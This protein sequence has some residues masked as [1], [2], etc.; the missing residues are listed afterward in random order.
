MEYRPARRPSRAQQAAFDHP[1]V[2]AIVQ[3]IVSKP[4]LVLVKLAARAII[5][6]GKPDPDALYGLV[7]PGL[8]ADDELGPVAE[9]IVDAGVKIATAMPLDARKRR[10]GAVLERLVYTL[11]RSGGRGTVLRE[12]EIR[13]DFNPRSRLQWSNAK[14]VL[15]DGAAFEVYECKADGLADVGDIDELSDIGTTAIAEGTNVR[16]TIAV[17]GSEAELRRRA[18]AWRMTETIYGVTTD[19]LLGLRS[20]LPQRPIRP[21]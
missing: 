9:R 6:D 15:V 19:G 12:Q 1:D 18:V 11:V 17:F 5:F 20:G 2:K 14:E 7:G 3:A 4:E 10:R 16:P 21:A 13:L 8:W